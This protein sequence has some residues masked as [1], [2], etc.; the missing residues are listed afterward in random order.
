VC[1][2]AD[3]MDLLRFK[4]G[5]AEWNRYSRVQHTGT[6]NANPLAATAGIAMLKQ[7]SSGERQRKAEAMARRLVDGWQGQLDARSVE[8]CAHNASS[9]L[10]LFLG[11]CQRCDRSICLDA[12]KKMDGRVALALDR[13]LLAQGVHLL[14]GV[15][16]W[17][18]AVHTDQDIEATID[19]FGHTLDGMIAE[20]VIAR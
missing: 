5:D 9:V 17:M 11:K 10:H 20:G 6:W 13:D 18:S 12:A 19:A 16:G 1:G 7:L 15:F 14:G 2:R 4:S 3:V 8:G